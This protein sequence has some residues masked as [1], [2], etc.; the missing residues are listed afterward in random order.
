MSQEEV[1]A[2]KIK[3]DSSAQED[4]QTSFQSQGEGGANSTQQDSFDFGGDSSG[5][6]RIKIRFPGDTIVKRSFP[7]TFQLT[8]E[9]VNGWA[10]GGQFESLPIQ[11]PF[12][13]YAA[14]VGLKKAKQMET[15]VL[16]SP[17]T[18]KVITKVFEAGLK[19]QSTIEEI[20]Q[21]L[22]LNR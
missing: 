14:K 19:A 21:K 17:V 20:R 13:R 7:K 16:E 6:E 5:P 11:N 2:V 8:E 18:E 22:N 9:I 10:Q 4:L 1:V 3:V 12:V 15:K